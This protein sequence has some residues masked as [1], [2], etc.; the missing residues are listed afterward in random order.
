MPLFHDTQGSLVETAKVDRVLV[1]AKLTSH[2]SSRLGSIFNRIPEVVPT[3]PSYPKPPVHPEL[4]SPWSYDVT[5][6]KGPDGKV[7]IIEFNRDLTTAGMA[8]DTN[9]LAT[10]RLVRFTEPIDR[11]APLK[12]LEFHPGKAKHVYYDNFRGTTPEQRQAIAN[13]FGKSPTP[14]GE[15]GRQRIMD[16]WAAIDRVKTP[17]PNKVEGSSLRREL[18][19][20]GT[21]LAAYLVKEGFKALEARD[22]HKM[23]EAVAQFG[24]LDFWK[25]VGAFTG[26]SW[27]ASYGVTKLSLPLWARGISKV[28]LPLAVG[29]A[30]VQWLSGTLSL[31]N[32]LVSTGSYLAAGAIVSSLA[33]AFVYPTLFS[34]GPPGWLAAGLYTT[35]KLALSLYVGEKLENWLHRRL[36]KKGVAPKQESGV[37]EKVDGVLDR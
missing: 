29:T 25:G 31:R 18:G 28:A 2:M 24:H 37:K 20:M 4:R 30:A 36:S 14:V 16:L 8:F 7:Y 19:G 6:G 3:L 15:N 27:L 12:Q 26:A 13:A 23:G 9:H 17:L 5:L 33:D 21:F 11:Y 34:A 32:F 1:G 10:A 22:P 35:G